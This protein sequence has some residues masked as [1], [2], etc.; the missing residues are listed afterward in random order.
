M[1]KLYE[2]LC[3][4]DKRNPMYKDLY[5]EDDNPTPRKDCFCDNCF[6]GIDKRALYTLELLEAAKLGLEVIEGEYP[7]D[8]EIAAPVMDKIKAAINKA[9]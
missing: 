3:Y 2:D 9:E 1:S 5:D 4:K 7:A 8:D 6:H